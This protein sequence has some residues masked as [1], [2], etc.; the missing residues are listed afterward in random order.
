MPL[1]ILAMPPPVIVAPLMTSMTFSSSVC[2]HPSGNDPVLVYLP[3]N[4]DEL[5]ITVS[6]NEPVGRS[7]KHAQT[8][9]T[10]K[11][12]RLSAA[13][14]KLAARSTLAAFSG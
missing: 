13:D 6:K 2:V 3:S 5:A 12:F 7:R 11:Y 14:G 8:E 9:S 10:G 1:A 4:G